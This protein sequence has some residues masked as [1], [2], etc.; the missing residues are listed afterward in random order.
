MHSLINVFL[1]CTFVYIMLQYFLDA[2]LAKEPVPPQLE[3]LAVHILV[4]LISTLHSFVDKVLFG[5]LSNSLFR[6]FG[7]IVITN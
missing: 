6:S 2:K 7:K 5:L 4:P 1:W 3:Q